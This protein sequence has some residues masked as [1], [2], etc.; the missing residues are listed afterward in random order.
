MLL[1]V[2]LEKTLESPLDSKEI[3]PI[4]PKGNHPW[5]FIGR[6]DAEAETLVIWP[7]DAKNWLEKT[8]M[9]GKIEDGRRGRQRMRW[10]DGITDSMDMS[11][12]KL[13]E[14]VMDRED[15]HAAVH[16]VTR[17]WTWLRDWIELLI[18]VLR[19]TIIPQQNF[20]LLLL[21]NHSVISNSLQPHGLQQARPPCPS[22]SPRVCPSSCSLHQWCHPA[23]SSSDALFSFC[24]LS[25]SASGLFQWVVCSHLVTKILELL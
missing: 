15:W 21:F 9:L 14:L 12:S 4:H 1:N 11:F 19:H 5:I 7:P 8:L 6:T 22:P 20:W 18:I 25:F 24:P 23:I 16:E 3:Q 2:V 10:L 13:W 17:S